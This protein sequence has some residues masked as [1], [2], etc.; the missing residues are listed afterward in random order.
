MTTIS[1]R[2]NEV[3]K[4]RQFSQEQLAEKSGVSQTTICKLLIGKSLESRKISH[5]ASALGVNTDWLALGKGNKY[6]FKMSEADSQQ[7]K[8]KA[9]IRIINDEDWQL[10]SPQTRALIE[11]ILNKSLTSDLSLNHIKLIQNM[12]DELIKD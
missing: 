5:I 2:L 9:H 11:V 12:V 7:L 6:P 10:L 4:E 1:N 8:L 3:M